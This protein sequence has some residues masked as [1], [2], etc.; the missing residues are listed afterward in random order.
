M[1]IKILDECNCVLLKIT[2]N[3]IEGSDPYEF[4]NIVKSLIAD[5]KKNIV[6]DLEDVG[7][8]NST[9]LS[10]LFRAHRT[11]ENVDGKFVLTNISERLSHLLSVTKLDTIFKIAQNK[12]EALNSLS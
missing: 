1:E 10:I 3:L 5:G 7:Y 8:V 2:G 12:E 6:A 9:G 4:N 11:I